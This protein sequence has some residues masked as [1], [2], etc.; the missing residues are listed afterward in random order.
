MGR[1]IIL[2]I[3]L[4]LAITTLCFAEGRV[5][6]RNDTIDLGALTEG[7]LY[8]FS[9][10]IQNSGEG[11]LIIKVVQST[12]GCVKVLE[13]QKEVII[14]PA[15]KAEVKYSVDTVGL[16]GE[17][18]K[19]LYI[20]TN[21]KNISVLKVVIKANVER[22]KEALLE[23][24]KL[25]G[26]GTV[27]VAGLI[28][29]INPCAFTVLVFFISFLTF[30]GYKKRQILIL[31]SFFILAVFMTYLLL[32]F[33]LFEFFRSLEVFSSLA[34]MVYYITAI[35]AIILGILSFYDYLIFKKTQDPERVSL[36][37]PEFIKKRIH[38]AIR[39]RT[40]RRTD[41]NLSK[42]SF[43]RLASAALSSGFIVSVLESVCTG[44]MYLP[45]II[46][47]LGVEHLKWRALLFLILYNLMFVFP[48]VIIFVFTLWGMTSQSFASLAKNH[49]AKVKIATSAV[50]LALG[51]GLLF[52][53]RK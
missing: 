7:K 48:L 13:P 36:K 34:R 22:K 29:G 47:I 27:I 35:L 31:G 9:F 4:S 38:S 25:W 32:G 50:F 18:V 20:H 11:D 26:I 15:G 51:L 46:Y 42:G 53:I 30:V 8:K 39:E 5:F 37:L 24:F 10:P 12:C 45:T 28:D 19:Y 23:R 49:L 52:I 44:Q 41:P 14:P 43:F 17:V 3:I 40:D 21:D 6:L 1:K 16:S 2:A 33:G